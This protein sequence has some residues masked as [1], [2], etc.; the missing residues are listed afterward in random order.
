[1]ITKKAARRVRACSM[2]MLG[3][4][5]AAATGQA[6]AQASQ[7]TPAPTPTPSPALVPGLEH[8]SLQPGA[9]S[10]VT[11]PLSTQT[12]PASS[13]PPPV[14]RTLPA[15]TPTPARSPRPVVPGPTPTRAPTQAPTLVPPPQPLAPPAALPTAV[16]TPLPT[17][18]PAPTPTGTPTAELL[19][20]VVL[21]PMPEPTS[22]PSP[23]A[24]ELDRG[25]RL[26]GWQ[27]Y[28]AIG[29]GAATL[30]LLGWLTF[31]WLRRREEIAD[32]PAPER[33]ANTTFDLGAADSPPA[34][35]PR[36]A[37]PVVAPPAPLPPEPLAA[38]PSPAEIAPAPVES[39]PVASQEVST[40]AW[41]DIELKPKRAGTNVLSAAVEYQILV[42][43][44][45]DAPARLVTTDVRILTAGVE[46]DAIL[47]ALFAAP[48]EKP[49]T[50]PFDMAPGETATLDGMAMMPRDALNV[51]T[52]EGR[53]LFVPVL[54]INLRYEWEGG[55][56][57]TA[58]SFVIGINRGEGAKM[59][60]FRVDGP[61]RMHGDVSQ[62]PYTVSV[63]S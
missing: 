53:A 1:M 60:P 37:A 44:A 62:I 9:G 11:R 2:L 16:P 4:A 45:G 24:P 5:T 34:L 15:P 55:T 58:N 38:A 10:R 23:A 56:G 29:G 3:V 54:A 43:N 26:N 36:P 52:V 48:I 47:Q 42:T 22:E 32:E 8:F 21:P 12:P 40:R 39:Q 28:A 27:A 35:P 13:G 6:W 61:P 33:L 30:F 63:R 17:P 18:I 14:V 31:L 19:P 57:Q 41:L 20:P 7:P 49:V 59:A 46:Q 51:M 50:A 25:Y